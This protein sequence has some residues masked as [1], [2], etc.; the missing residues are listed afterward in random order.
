MNTGIF[1]RHFQKI[2]CA[3]EVL[4]G[5]LKEVWL[6]LSNKLF[7]I[8][9]GKMLL[10][11]G[12]LFLMTNFWLKCYTQH[13]E[14]VHVND[15]T[16]MHLTDARKVSASKGFEFIIIDSV[17]MDGRP[18]GIIIQQ[19][20]KPNAGVKEGRKIYVTVT[21][22][23]GQV[24]LPGL[25]ESSYDFERYAQKLTRLGIKSKVREKVYDSRQAPNTILYLNYMDRK[26]TD[27]DIR[28]GFE[29]MMGSTVEAVVT[30]RFSNEVEI[31]ELVCRTYEEAVFL[32]SSSGFTVGIVNEDPTV[33]DRS[34]AYVYMQEPAFATGQYML[35]GTQFQLWLTQ[36]LP[37]GCPDD[38][39]TGN[40]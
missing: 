29:V 36:S 23:P 16:G 33:T 39:S 19:D 14:S 35:V 24:R 31:P 10:L 5:I 9:I 17:W 38:Q 30:E 15:F 12:G 37:D 13:G 34:Q 21:G 28:N 1:A 4:K 18:G 2:Q 32:L 27:G 3:L 25:A 7:L 26:V 20:P 11:A 6:F 8:N 40:F 22:L